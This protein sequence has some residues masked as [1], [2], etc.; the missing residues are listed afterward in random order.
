MG[1]ELHLEYETIPFPRR[2]DFLIMDRLRELTRNDQ[3]QL[4]ALARVRG[5]LNAIFFSD[6]V[7]ADGKYLEQFAV[8]PRT[9][10]VPRSKYIF[11]REEPSDK[12]WELWISYLKSMTVGNYELPTPIGIWEKPTHR[13]WSWMTDREEEHLYEKKE[14][15][16]KVHVRQNGR[17]VSE[18]LTRTLL[19]GM[20]ASVMT[21][22]AGRLRL[23]SSCEMVEVESVEHETFSDLLDKWGGAWMWEHV[24]DDTKN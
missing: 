2:G 5:S 19:N 23:R 20:P 3:E 9:E 8:D 18:G 24:T 7:T 21:D 14:D 6:L 16:W 12:D 1:F 10:W 11:P 17:W 13:A 15:F 4:K 22:G